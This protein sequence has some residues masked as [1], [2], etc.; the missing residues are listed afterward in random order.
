M[1][2]N[3]RRV[4]SA[5]VVAV[6]AGLMVGQGALAQSE[7]VL[8]S[9]PFVGITYTNIATSLPRPVSINAVIIDLSAP[10]LSFQMTPD[11][12]AGA[13]ETNE[14]TTLGFMNQTGA[15]LA[16][17]THFFTLDSQPTADLLGLAASNGNA[18]SGWQS[19][20]L[21]AAFNLS[22]S[23]QLTL[24]QPGSGGGAFETNPSVSLYNAFGTALS[25]GSNPLIV[26][27]GA[28]TSNNSSFDLTPNPRTAAAQLPGNRLLLVTVD[29]RQPGVSEGMTVPELADLM[30]SRFGAINAINLDGGGSTTMAMNAAGNGRLMNVPVG[31]GSGQGA[32]QTQRANG[33]NLA[34]FAAR[35]VATG[36][37]SELIASE[38]FDYAARNWGTDATA[39]PNGGG[40][41]A[42]NGGH[43]WLSAW[44]DTGA[45]FGGIA[46]PGPGFG[47]GISGDSRTAPL[48]FT[49]AAGASVQAA[50]G[51]YRGAF[52][53]SSTSLRQIDTSRVNPSML[54]SNG[55]IGADGSEVWV[56]F[57]AQSFAA[58][59]TS[60]STQ[61]FAYLQLGSN[62]RLGKLDN[63]PTGNWGVQ[64][65]SAGGQIAFSSLASNNQVMYLAKI[66][67]RNGAE[68]VSIWLNPTSL[69]NQALLGAPSMQIPV[70]N[71]TFADLSIINRYSTDFDEIRLGTSFRSVVPT[72]GAAGV[73]GLGAIAAFRRRR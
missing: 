34:V 61:R 33:A 9:T 55:Q 3:S 50:G 41:N 64:D 18:Y 43:G 42:L 24:I 19:G 39:R 49:D 69:T 6:L 28:N 32:I 15:Q 37:T 47:T 73:L 40:V 27:G 16:I 59:G 36:P 72:P 23:N 60:G 29:G 53:T 48:A 56:S 22:Q 7:S 31:V 8:T 11:N 25:N 4:S 35:A 38:S 66:E 52:G 63:S 54:A 67:F 70:A 5:A 57:L 1:Q 30:I 21:N 26:S 71:F 62:L 10:G 17:N 68:L 45:R 14:Q 12:G 46:V 58:A 2:Q 20:S 13:Q 65:A 44:A 51:Q